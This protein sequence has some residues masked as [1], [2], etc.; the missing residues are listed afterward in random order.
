MKRYLLIGLLPLLGILM[1]G[2][3]DDE[4][5]EDM[6]VG[7]DSTKIVFN[8][9]GE[10]EYDPIYRHTERFLESH[11]GKVF[12]I[13]L[14]RYILPDGKVDTSVEAPQTLFGITDPCLYY[15][16]KETIVIFNVNDRTVNQ[17]VRMNVSYD[18]KSGTIRSDGK[19]VAQLRNTWAV[20]THFCAGIF[21]YGEQNGK[22]VY[23]RVSLDYFM[24]KDYFTGLDDL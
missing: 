5:E 21:Y 10:P 1:I 14:F 9:Q 8:E 23:V 3:H 18:L 6:I 22:A 11:F 12:S 17:S 7:G 4:K 19:F 13:A 2:C 16:D 20:P 24:D 15:K